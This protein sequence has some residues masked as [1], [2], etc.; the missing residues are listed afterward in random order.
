[1]SGQPR[2]VG[3]AVD[4]V[5]VVAV[6]VSVVVGVVAIVVGTVD[7]C[8]CTSL[9]KKRQVPSFLIKKQKTTQMHQK[10]QISDVSDADASDYFRTAA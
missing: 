10:F 3:V 7:V 2:G 8:V 5:A 1:M 4:G 9:P 6:V